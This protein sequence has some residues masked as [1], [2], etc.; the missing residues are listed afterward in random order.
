MKYVSYWLISF[1]FIHTQRKVTAGSLDVHPTEKALVVHY[2]VEASILG[3]GGGHMLGERKE[4][5]KMWVRSWF[6][7]EMEWLKRSFN[8]FFT[9]SFDFVFPLSAL[10]PPSTDLHCCTQTLFISLPFFC[11]W[12]G[13]I[14]SDWSLKSPP[15]CCCTSH[16]SLCPLVL[17]PVSVWKVSLPV[18]MWGLWP[19]KLWRSVSSSLL[20]VYLRWSSSFT[21]CRTGS[22]HQW[23]AK[24]SHITIN[25]PLRSPN[26]HIFISKMCFVNGTSCS[27]APCLH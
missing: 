26:V 1:L 9:V 7:I 16:P 4:G 15:C 19:R 27:L 13:F 8:L 12:I 17:P 3:E 10:L 11:I 2:E 25:I 20:P 21:T 6:F 18:Q 23:R 5:Q 24:V 14:K 22:H